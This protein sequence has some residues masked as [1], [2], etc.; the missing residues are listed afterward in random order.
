MISPA[1]VRTLAAYNAEMNR[2]IYRSAETLDED[3]RRADLGAFFGSIHA[4]LSHLCWADGV[5]MHRLAG[6]PAIG[7]NPREG[8][9][10]HPDWP[11][12][13]A[14]RAEMDAGIMAWAAA[15]EAAALDGDLTWTNSRGITTTKPRWLVVAHMCNHGTHHRGQVHALLTRLGAPVED[16]DLPWVV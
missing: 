5:W 8:A 16:T 6:W 3:R 7:G 12:M 13:R 9:G 14:L 1:F 10:R 2:R 15:L 4:T 11:A